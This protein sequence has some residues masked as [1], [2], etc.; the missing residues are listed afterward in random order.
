VTDGRDSVVKLLRLEGR[1]SGPHSPQHFFNEHQPQTLGRGGVDLRFE[2]G[3][4]NRGVHG[5]PR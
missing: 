2:I 3:V 1:M 4:A 5:I